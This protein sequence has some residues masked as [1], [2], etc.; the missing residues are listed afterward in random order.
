MNM[1]PVSILLDDINVENFADMVALC[2]TK[3]LVVEREMLAI[4]V[5]SGLIEASR[6]PE[7]KRLCGVRYVEEVR[8][9]RGM[10]KPLKP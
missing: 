8:A 1:V 3:G 7:L 6:I 9:V 10:V 4:G 5:I 2:Q